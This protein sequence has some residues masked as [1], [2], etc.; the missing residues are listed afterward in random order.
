VFA[1]DG[2]GELPAP[3]PASATPAPGGPGVVPPVPVA[4]EQR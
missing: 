3:P 1:L 2:T 4:P